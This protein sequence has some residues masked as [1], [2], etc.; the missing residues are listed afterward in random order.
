MK[1]IRKLKL[2]FKPVSRKSKD[3]LEKKLIK[4]LKVALPSL[5][6]FI[7]GLNSNDVKDCFIFLERN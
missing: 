1:N 3:Y 6:T 2:L 5:D 4:H 7:F